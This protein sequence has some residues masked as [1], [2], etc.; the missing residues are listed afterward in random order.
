M[1]RA[2]VAKVTLNL[3]T[4]EALVDRLKVDQALRR[5]CG[6]S[7]CHRI[8]GKHRFSRAFAEFADLR[9]AERRHETLIETHLGDQLIGHIAR[10][11]TAITAREKSAGKPPDSKFQSTPRRRGRPRRGEIVPPKPE[12]RLERQ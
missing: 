9:L 5:L 11:S 1:A 3:P 7:T 12:T 10:D 2:F 4:T 8:P 6:V